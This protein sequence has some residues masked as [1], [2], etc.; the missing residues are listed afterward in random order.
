MSFINVNDEAFNVLINEINTCK[1]W[2]FY[3]LDH[4]YNFV[5]KTLIKWCTE[6][7]IN[8][9]I[10]KTLISDTK[11]IYSPNY[12]VVYES[13]KLIEIN[14]KDK[15]SKYYKN[16]NYTVIQLTISDRVEKVKAYLISKHN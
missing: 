2:G 1:R 5:E 8:D 15:L 11:E 13:K 9:S 14:N 7:H 4:Q 12:C 6:N 10:L 16:K 3:S